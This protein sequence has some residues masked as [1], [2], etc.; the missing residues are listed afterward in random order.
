MTAF[1]ALLTCLSI[2]I[3]TCVTIPP[4]ITKQGPKNIFYKPGETVKIECEASGDPK[5]S[6]YWKRAEVIFSPEGNDDRIVKQKD[7]GTLII[8]SPED[9]DEGI[10]QCFASNSQGTA[11]T[12]KF[13]LKMAKLS[14]F[15]TSDSITHR[16]QLG[17]S[18]TLN[19]QSPDSVPDA[20]IYWVYGDSG[21]FQ[22]VFWNNRVTMDYEDRLYFTYVTPEDAQGGKPYH[23]VAYNSLMRMSV[24]G[25][26]H[27]IK[28]QGTT[29]IMSPM[30]KL[31]PTSRFDVQGQVGSEFKMKCIFAGNP[32]PTVRW[33]RKDGLPF[34]K[35]VLQG[36]S[37]GQE[38]VIR[39]LQ[40]DDAGTYMCDGTRDQEST[41]IEMSVNLNVNSPPIWK[42]KPVD[43]IIGENG[44]AEFECAAVGVPKPQVFWFV[45]GEPLESALQNDKR[46]DHRFQH[47]KEDLIV[48]QKVTKQDTMVFQCNVTNNQGHQW[49]EA[50]LNVLSEAP[51]I[52]ERPED[53]IVAE[54]QPF[55]MACYITGKPDP[56]ITWYR[57]NEQVT[58]GR[59]EISK[60]G[61]LTVKTAVL[62][63]AGEYRCEAYNVFGLETASATLIVRRKT[64]IEWKPMDLEV[65]R[66]VNA[67]FTCSG[68]T[69]PEESDNM[70][71]SW[72]KDGS[73]V[74]LGTRMFSNIQDHSLTISGC[75][76]RDTGTYTCV[77]SN[78]L[79]NDT[80]SARLVVT[81]IP[82]APYDIKIRE[83]CKN[84]GTAQL[85]WIAG[86]FNNAPTE[87]FLIEYMTK[88]DPNRWVFAMQVDYRKDTALIPLAAGMD[89]V[90][91]VT[92]Y[93][94]IGASNPSIPS[95]TTCATTPATPTQNPRNLRTIGDKIGKLHIVWTPVPPENQGG[96]NFSYVL[97]LQEQGTS[98]SGIIKPPAITDWRTSEFTYTSSGV[99]YSRYNITISSLNSVGYSAEQP[100]T[101]YGYSYESTPLI[102]PSGLSVENIQ[103]DNAVF[104]WTFDRSEIGKVRSKIQGE[105]RG[106]KVQFWEQNRQSE[107]IREY[108]VPPEDVLGNDTSNT[109]RARVPNLTPNTHLQARVTLLNNFFVSKPSE[110]ISFVTPPGLPGAIELLE[111]LN[112]GDNHINLQWRSPLDNR[113]D[114]I[115]YDIGYQE[116]RGL[117]LEEMQDRLPQ[118]DDPFST[119]AMLS[120]LKPN[121]KY[122]VT[123]WARTAAGRGDGYYIERT[124]GNPGVPM[125]P[126]FTI[127]SVGTNFI[128]ITWWRDAYQASGSIVYV[129][130]M[131]E[132]SAEWFSTTPDVS[133]DWAKVSFLQPGT[134]YTIRIAVTNGETRRISIEQDVRTDGTAKAYD[135]AANLG[136]F[137][138]V[139]FSLLLEI[140]LV[141]LF[142]VC[143]RRGFRFKPTDQEIRTF[144]NGS[145]TYTDKEEIPRVS[146]DFGP[147]PGGYSNDIYRNDFGE[148]YDDDDD[149]YDGHDNSNTYGDPDYTDYDKGI[150]HAYRDEYEDEDVASAGA[151]SDYEEYDLEKPRDTSYTSD[152]S[153]SETYTPPPDAYN[154][155]AEGRR[156]PYNGETNKSRIDPQKREAYS[157]DTTKSR[158]RNSSQ[159]EFVSE[160]PRRQTGQ[161][162]KPEDYR[163]VR[164]YVHRPADDGQESR[165]HQAS[166][167]NNDGRSPRDDQHN[168][169]HDRQARRYD[170]RHDNEK[171]DDVVE[172]F[173]RY[174]AVV[175]DQ[176]SSSQGSRHK[177][178][179]IV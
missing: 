66:G 163:D 106:F 105:F 78:G 162:R 25:P 8:N 91:R 77:V 125:M 160:S 144:R 60:T 31:W 88:V 6:Y 20:T 104:T 159:E 167:S 116:V 79:D 33:K 139:V 132:D 99:P 87:Y 134:K 74:D 7:V 176:D 120:G 127:A 64:V 140:A 84:G 29:L 86:S 143:Y 56:I 72:L 42:S 135:V 69:D 63:D 49:G 109:F 178:S 111:D 5:P 141:I 16:P 81:D 150:K 75:E 52:L 55:D 2:G 110:T 44:T 128:N 108:N 149:R 146:K 155:S 23:C 177:H 122:R 124:T 1:F 21:E 142:V 165:R 89:Y 121:T 85:E 59:Y 98:T 13:N 152:H 172:E 161:P 12:I 166:R 17:T 10:Y 18:L 179:T 93:N 164:Q 82:D 131:K 83:E 30:R 136:W 157:R 3:V 117:R 154:S 156:R 76:Q 158:Y 133:R 129:E 71:T 118:I 62:S 171:H 123:V 68:T 97:T 80:A 137:L 27:Y 36:N 53:S 4:K 101:I 168:S 57:N 147:E 19:C 24:V 51:T 50:F 70:V 102:W 113:G 138:G 26:P 73:P 174:S 58:G 37:G 96:K 145:E 34:D 61:S 28:P 151:R 119:T 94:K 32:T 100:S 47:L 54:G 170:E 15:A 11:A 9:K 39:D 65:Q 14:A 114:V 22:P 169:G 40:F 148:D 112:V 92:A 90:F 48:L 173:K 43:V 35:R 67:K 45:N 103:S 175:P 38:L 115:G 107:T 130:Y 46:L 95:N 41:P 153:R 126:R